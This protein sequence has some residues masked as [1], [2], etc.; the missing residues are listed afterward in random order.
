MKPYQ[1]L[2]AGMLTGL[3]VGFVVA[4]QIKPT[5]GNAESAAD[6]PLRT[7]VER[8]PTTSNPLGKPA[9]SAVL[10]RW[11][12]LQNDDDGEGKREALLSALCKEEFPQ[13]LAEISSKARFSGLD[14]PSQLHDFFKAWHSKAP[15]AALVWLRTLPKVQDRQRLML[16]IVDEV[17]ESNLEDALA[18]LRQNVHAEGYISITNMVLEKAAAQGAEKLM[19]V[20]KL[21]IGAVERPVF[22][23]WQVSFP[24]GF[25][26]K[27]VLD[28]LA[29]TKAEF[30]EG[31]RFGAV[32]TNLLSEWGNRDFQAALAWLK[33]G[34]D[35]PDNGCSDLIA[36][37]PPAQ[38]GALL[39]L[40]FDPTAPESNRYKDVA[41]ALYRITS[42]E[43]LDA[44]L[45]AA[46]GE[47][48]T[49]IGGL[50]D[51]PSCIG[52]FQAL[53]L[54]R[55]SAELRAEA[56]SRNFKNGVDPQTKSALTRLLVGLGHSEVE[57]QTLLPERK[58]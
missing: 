43:I 54:E 21:G 31:E 38:A 35:V 44:F 9:P 22:S 53:L 7:R 20:C 40:T 28:D 41:F 5:A 1:L 42:S 16:E 34:K 56:L 32:P 24:E 39:A 30:G 23:S 13:L 48:A 37:V 17:A 55:M 2:G 49:H 10:Q 57:I 19:E 15:D 47:R 51:E 58:D 50:F 11:E 33:E 45:Q 4:W 29:A 12:E 8:R 14:D 18:M 26:F 27:R 36:A 25:D 46:P 52:E 3:V 6:M